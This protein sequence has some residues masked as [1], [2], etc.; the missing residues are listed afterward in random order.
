MAEARLRVR[1]PWAMV[2]PKG[3]NELLVLG[4]AGEGVDAGLVQREPAADA[5]LLADQ[6]R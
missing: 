2:P 6:G 3:V 4:Q 1:K 5:D